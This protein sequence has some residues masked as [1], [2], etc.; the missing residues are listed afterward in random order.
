MTTTEAD[1][2]A[3]AGKLTEEAVRQAWRDGFWVG[4]RAGARYVGYVEDGLSRE[5]AAQRAI[6]DLHAVWAGEPFGDSLTPR[7]A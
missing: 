2:V 3:L 7:S 1:L 6:E 5:D 4:F